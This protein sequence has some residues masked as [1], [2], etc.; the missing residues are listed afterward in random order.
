M[1]TLLHWQVKQEFCVFVRKMAI[2]YLCLGQCPVNLVKV[3]ISLFLIP[4]NVESESSAGTQD[5]FTV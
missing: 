1:G 4:L 5:S 2:I 3:N